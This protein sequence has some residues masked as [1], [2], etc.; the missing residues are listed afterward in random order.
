MST[1]PY[2]L[3][4]VFT[5][6]K[7]FQIF[8]CKSQTQSLFITAVDYKRAWSAAPCFPVSQKWLMGATLLSTGCVGRSLSSGY[9]PS[10]YMLHYLHGLLRF[11]L[12]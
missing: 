10:M 4:Q 2:T 8:H 3:N 1:I 9:T 5:K 12:Q 6:H 11:T 7:F